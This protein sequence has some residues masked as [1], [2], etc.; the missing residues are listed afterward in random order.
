MKTGK[1]KRFRG[2][3]LMEIAICLPLLVLIA[4]LLAVSLNGFRRLNHYQLTKQQ[5]VAAA[6]AQLE[7]IAATAEHLDDDNI[8]RLWPK[9]TL[10]IESADGTG[11]WKGL[12]LI[13][14]TATAKSYGK[15]VSV[16]LSRYI[17][18]SRSH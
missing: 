8:R 7:S 15:N 17:L 18:E 16:T 4:S 10:S 3:L 9:V 6:Q 2:W 13:K 5:C 14:V 12:K 1:N 11:Q